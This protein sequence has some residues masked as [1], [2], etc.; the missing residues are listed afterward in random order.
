MIQWSS[1]KEPQFAEA[2][3]RFRTVRGGLTENHMVEHFDLQ[4]LAGADQIARHLDVG[5]GGGRVVAGVIVHQRNGRS[6][7]HD[8]AFED[9]AWMHQQRIQCAGADDFKPD[10]VAPRVEMHDDE[11][12]HVGPVIKLSASLGRR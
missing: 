8:C 3:P 7:R 10:G 12:L 6:V 4:K 9:F 1:V 5:F 11:I 2:R